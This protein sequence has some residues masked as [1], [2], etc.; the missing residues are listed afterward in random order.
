[1]AASKIEELQ[2]LSELQ[3]LVAAAKEDHHDVVFPSHI[4]RK[5]GEL[6]GYAGIFSTPILM[7]WLDTKKGNARDTLEMLK[8]IENIAKEK[9]V[10]RYVTICSE[11]SP[12]FKHMNRL[13]YSKL[14]KTIMF[15]KEI[16]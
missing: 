1:M 8:E 12:Y 15:Q 7:W 13:G 9:Q 4:V 6:I 11:D 10:K 5:N 2:S 16:I 3:E 14:G